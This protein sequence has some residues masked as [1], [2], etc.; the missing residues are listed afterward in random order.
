MGAMVMPQTGPR[1]VI[2]KGK[3]TRQESD[4]ESE[5]EEDDEGDDDDDDADNPFGDRNA[6][7]TPRL[8]KQGYTW[9][10]I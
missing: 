1:T 4:L 7:G 3:T 5:D 10:E 8:E 9:R 2:G 6:T